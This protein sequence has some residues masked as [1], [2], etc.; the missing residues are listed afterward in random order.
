MPD[1]RTVPNQKIVNIHRDMPQKGETEPFLT[2]KTKNL[3][4]A[5]RNLHSIGGLALYLYFASNKD[6]YSFALSPQAIE[7]EIGIPHTT[8][9]DN[10]NRLILNGYL[11]R[12]GNGNVYDFRETNSESGKEVKP[13]NSKNENEIPKTEI[14]EKPPEFEF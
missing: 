6:G 7:N 9:N 3:F 11:V 8:Y 14:G 4:E 5:Y 13:Q 10:I 1:F 12:R 2:I